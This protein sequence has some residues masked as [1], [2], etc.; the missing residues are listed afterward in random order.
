MTKMASLGIVIGLL[1]TGCGVSSA[2]R[3][4]LKVVESVDV[5]QYLGTWYEIARYP[6]R[7]QKNCFRS[8]AQYSLREDGDLKVVNTCHKGSR[9]GEMDTANGKA[10]VVDKVTNAKLKVQFFWPFSGDY[11][12]IDLGD[13][14]E[15]AVIGEPKREY[16]WI[17]SRQPQMAQDTYRQL[18]KGIAEQGY[19]PNRLIRK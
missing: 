4:P 12:I 6:N 13:N 15:Y 14:Y 19:D 1:G 18:A 5:D 10:W 8:R 16:L 3:V 17:L 2:Q 9:D 11:W 7:F